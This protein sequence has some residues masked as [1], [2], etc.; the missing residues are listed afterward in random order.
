MVTDLGISVIDATS[1]INGQTARLDANRIK[2]V[3]SEYHMGVHRKYG[4]TLEVLGGWSLDDACLLDNMVMSVDAELNGNTFDVW[5]GSYGGVDH[6]NWSETITDYKPVNQVLRFDDS[7]TEYIVLATGFKFPF[8]AAGEQFEALADL[9]AETPNKAFR[10]IYPYIYVF[11]EDREEETWTTIRTNTAN[12]YTKAF[13]DAT[14]NCTTPA[15]AGGATA[16]LLN[17]DHV[18][19]ALDMVVYELDMVPKIC[20]HNFPLYMLDR[21]IDDGVNPS[22]RPNYNVVGDSPS[23]SDDWQWKYW[24]NLIWAFLDHVENRYGRGEISKWKFSVFGET[25]FPCYFFWLSHCPWKTE[26]DGDAIKVYDETLEAFKEYQG[27]CTFGD[28]DCYLEFQTWD[29]GGGYSHCSLLLGS[30]V[31]VMGAHGQYGGRAGKIPKPINECIHALEDAG[32]TDVPVDYAST[33]P[34]GT[35]IDHVG[36]LHMKGHGIGNRN[37]LSPN[38]LAQAVYYILDSGTTYSASHEIFKTQQFNYFMAAQAVQA[39]TYSNILQLQPRFFG[40]PRMPSPLF[41]G[42][43]LLSRVGDLYTYSVIDHNTLVCLSMAD[44]HAPNG[45]YHMV[46]LD[47]NSL[48]INYQTRKSNSITLTMDG[49][50]DEVTY[51]LRE[52]K[53][54]ETHGNG[55][56]ESF[57]QGCAVDP[58]ECLNST[59]VID[60]ITGNANTILDNNTTVTPTASGGTV[61]LSGRTVMDWSVYMA[62]IMGPPVL[63]KGTNATHT[64]LYSDMAADPVNGIYIVYAR[65]DQTIYYQKWDPGDKMFDGCTLVDLSTDYAYNPR[66]AVDVLWGVT[67]VVSLNKGDSLFLSHDDIHPGSVTVIKG[68]TNYEKGDD[69][70]IDY[71]MGKLYA[72]TTLNSATVKYDSSI[73][74]VVWVEKETKSSTA[75]DI[76][77]NARDGGTYTGCGGWIYD[78]GTVLYGLTQVPG[79][80]V[81][82]DIG[83]NPELDDDWFHLVWTEL[84]DS[85]SYNIYYHQ[86]KI[87]GLTVSL[88]DANTPLNVSSS[89]NV[90][91]VEPKIGVQ[92]GDN[93]NYGG[94]VWTEKT[95][96][97]HDIWVAVVGH[98]LGYYHKTGIFEVISTSS[99]NAYSPDCASS[100]FYDKYVAHAVWVEDKNGTTPTIM[101]RAGIGTTQGYDYLFGNTVIELG[102]GTQVSIS[103][104]PFG[105][106]H[107]AYNDGDGQDSEIIYKKLKLMQDGGTWSYYITTERTVSNFDKDGDSDYPVVLAE[108]GGN[109]NFLWR[110]N[111]EYFYDSN[112]QKK[113]IYHYIRQ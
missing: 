62:E 72:G 113:L 35:P 73:P 98:G 33:G 57:Y 15:C 25:A 26:I 110:D 103:S 48:D 97:D 11:F 87:D 36:Q 99:D 69:Y 47:S 49:L 82:L 30:S 59:T 109:L 63:S 23:N 37:N 31:S 4:S 3:F 21:M 74:H 67:D 68:S 56:F 95:S 55:H 83:I 66:I 29:R 96:G 17:W 65:D 84:E 81:G 108:P 80:D 32:M 39:G 27:D 9:N 104:G 86:G 79:S 85:G 89:N 12:L 101:Y 28:G 92:K 20:F 7:G 13:F 112:T 16:N 10:E 8:A 64:Y 102:Q 77:I 1:I 44:S 41:H 2:R 46:V 43:E 60:D 94:I 111:G 38:Y 105:A 5:V 88:R 91:S 70:T 51:E 58:G 107:V 54:N 6:S 50:D 100:Y 24:D 14:T 78:G 52:Y 34:F 61:T 53:I 19:K 75:V 40:T 93:Y 106:V 42:W 22:R 76:R 45:L 18:E 71:L 90:D